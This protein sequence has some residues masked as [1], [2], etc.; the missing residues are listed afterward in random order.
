[1]AHP[2]VATFP[3]PKLMDWVTNVQ[4]WKESTLSAEGDMATAS[5]RG[6]RN[7]SVP[8]CVTCAIPVQA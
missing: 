2:V 5:C 6:H 8:K 7:R 4:L 3:E 1:M